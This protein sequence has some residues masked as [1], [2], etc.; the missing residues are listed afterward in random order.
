MI[1][2]KIV[3]LY[4][5]SEIRTVFRIRTICLTN[6]FHSLKTQFHI[7]VDGKKNKTKEIRRTIFETIN[8]RYTGFIS[9]STSIDIMPNLRTKIF[10]II[11]LEIIIILPVQVC[12]NFT[13]NGTFN[14]F[15]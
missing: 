11:L 5:F 1:Q 2:N 10:E 3:Q 12:L 13:D 4:R 7:R 14:L 6:M 8:L 9:L 15:C